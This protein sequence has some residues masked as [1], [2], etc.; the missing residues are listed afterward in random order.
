MEGLKIA[1]PNKGRMSDD[2][3]ELLNRAGLNFDSH[4]RIFANAHRLNNAFVVS[5]CL[6]L[7]L[8]QPADS[9]LA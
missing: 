6:P 5:H 8:Q 1:I 3:F 7:F 2:I 4:L 9:R